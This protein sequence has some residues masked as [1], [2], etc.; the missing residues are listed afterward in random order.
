MAENR[1]GE[2]RRSAV[3]MTFGPGAIVDFR[4]D[5]GPV[6]AVAAGLEEWDSSFPP[7][8]LRNSQKISEPRL[9]RKLAVKG[10]RLP[11]VV[12]ENWR[13][14]NGNP[15]RRTLVAARFPEWLQCPQCDR[16]S[17]SGKWGQDPGRAYRYCA[18]CTSRSPPCVRRRSCSRISI[19]PWNVR[20]CDA[21]SG[22]LRIGPGRW[23]AWQRRCR[24]T[25]RWRQRWRRVKHRPRRS[26][27]PRG[28]P[29]GYIR[30]SA[31]LCSRLFCWDCSALSGWLARAVCWASY[32][33]KFCL[34]R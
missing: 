22:R 18:R 8:G 14:D 25:I 12:D 3:V 32:A 6:S 1:L 13:D 29:E 28:N 11:P 21:S 9:Q 5:G 20:S 31:E 2:L 19:R 34:P 17:P 16:I 33:A 7:A 10:F 24:E 4:A 26:W 27:R 15:D 30:R 23:R